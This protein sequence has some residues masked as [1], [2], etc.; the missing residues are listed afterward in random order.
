MCSCSHMIVCVFCS[1]A[2]LLG[3]KKSNEEKTHDLWINSYFLASERS[4]SMRFSTI[5]LFASLFCIHHFLK[6]ACNSSDK[7]PNKNT[8]IQKSPLFKMANSSVKNVR[9]K[10]RDN[11]NW[12]TMHWHSFQK[13]IRLFDHWNIGP[14]RPFFKKYP[15]P[16]H[17]PVIRRLSV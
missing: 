15:G 2:L 10:K 11:G 16:E 8:R 6:K 13:I 12:P 17:L 9:V 4:T 7:N 1:S 3:W 5:Y 14:N